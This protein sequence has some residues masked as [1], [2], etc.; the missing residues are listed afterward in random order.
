MTNI[1]EDSPVRPVLR[2]CQSKYVEKLMGAPDMIHPA[3]SL[4]HWTQNQ[5][6]RSGALQVSWFV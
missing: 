2:V 1:Y 4:T 5:H 3:T 6:M